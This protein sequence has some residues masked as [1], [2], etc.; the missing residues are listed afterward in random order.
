M[1]RNRLVACA[2]VLAAVI[3]GWWWLHRRTAPDRAATATGSGV[4]AGS[5]R[6]ERP[7][8]NGDVSAQAR[9]MIDD[10]PQGS[11]RLE[12]QVIDADDHGVAGATV[13]LA[14]NPPRTATTET[15]GG[16]AFDGLIGRPYT[17]TARAA[18]GTAGPIT[19]RLTEKSGPVVLRLRPAAKLTVT[20]VGTSGK[21]IEGA[22]VELRGLDTRR[23]AV[24]GKVAVFSPVVPG[25][26]QI[27]AWADGMAHAF[28]WI[29][30]GAG[31]AEARLTLASGAAVRGRVVD[32]R[33]TGVAG[34]RVRYS[35][36]S[37]WSQQA[38]D[39]LDGAVTASDGSFQFDALPAGSF[40]FLAS[41]PERAPGTSPLVTLDGKTVRDGVVIELA[42]GAIVKGH[43]VDRQHQ[44]VASAR[45]RIGPAGGP[46]AAQLEAPRQAY[47][48]AQGGFEIK[49]L[50]RKALA[51][52]ALHETGSSQI[53]AVDATG[54][55]VAELTLTI[56]VTG[57][58]AGQV[59][60]PQGQPVEGAQVSAGPVFGAGRPPNDPAQFRL[61]GFP[62]D[63]TDASGHFQLTGL[64]PG[65][66]RVSAAPARA[67]GRGR[68]RGGSRDGVTATTGDSNVKLVLEPD[69]GVKGTVAFAD[70]SVPDLFSVG[71]QQNQQSFAGGDGKFV[72]DGL[73]P[74]TYE[75]VVRGPSFQTQAAQVAIEAAN[76][77]D[78]G[79]ITVVKGRSIAGIVVA[80]GQP[81]PDATVYA[82]RTVFG[83][84]TTSSVQLGAMGAGLG[85]ATKT[86][87]TDASGAFSL[88]GFNDGDL[89]LVAEQDA[90]GRSRALRLPT[91]MPGQ[92]E[93]TISL[94][95][96]GALTGTLRQGG[97]PAD[98]V[99][100]TCQ[101]TS[102]PGA[103]YT[104][105]AG[106]D[107]AYRFDRLAPDTYKVSA[108]LGSPRTG[109]KFYSKQI[110]VPAGQ[111]V[112]VDLSV[113][114]G[115]VTLAVA[116]TARGGV[117]AAS[118]W[119]ASGAITASTASELS[120]K[121]AAAGPGASQRVPVRA[122]EPAQFTSVAPAAYTACV[123][124]FPLEVPARA[125]PAYFD[126]HGDLLPTFC[127]AIT[128]AASPDTQTAEIAVE[129]PPFIPDGPGAGS[130]A[131]PGSGTGPGPGSGH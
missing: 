22:T 53:V 28:H 94:E 113:D 124:P 8:R 85:G 116:I 111:V 105:A 102:T 36:A 108:T 93:L 103:V 117:G 110:D 131:G 128:V 77:A 38:S 76:T 51:A 17:L 13:V 125:A 61:R 11:L 118:A 107:G 45:V 49:G 83:N 130:G 92:T 104:V 46:R 26:Y 80:D 27:A 7:D 126:R 73:A 16:F 10:D 5:A 33:G 39:R 6:R 127:K 20:V 57:T 69:G 112:T 89:T 101:S 42:V 114:A 32:D 82:G 23:A 71:V 63:A 67:G 84:G 48:D 91:V 79:T 60:D 58:I 15:D 65:Q 98:R 123:T 64:A 97:A 88:S 35:G 40:R 18:G 19:A 56:D 70:G 86:T 55:D 52:L 43:V 4:P 78:A 115:T 68:G 81:V 31:D 21:A 2:L 129:L 12:G 121:L 99:L 3:G 87:T 90:I 59:V 29:V 72:L 120:L 62:E 100:V 37:D 34:A 24:K 66:Y 74:G 1:N 25:G 54:G 106:A 109:M 41:H 119:L 14:A 75:L 30:I 122:G 50:P 9:V 95:K 44:P 96:F 47:S